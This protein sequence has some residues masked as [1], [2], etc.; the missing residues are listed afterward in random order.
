MTIMTKWTIVHYKKGTMTMT[1]AFYI[2]HTDS[3]GGDWYMLMARK[4]HFCISCGGDLNKRLEVL[5]DCVKRH[6]TEQRL[7]DSLSR[8]DCGGKVSPATFEQREE[9]FREKGEDFKDLVESVVLEAL[10]EAREEDKANNP[11]TKARTRLQKAGGVKTIAKAQE[12]SPAI[13]TATKKDS[14]KLLR[15]PRVFNRK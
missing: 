10:K 9:Y 14:P 13:D 4:T 8:L 6:R 1:S 7:L 3:I 5:K 11:L 12:V 15:K 2:T